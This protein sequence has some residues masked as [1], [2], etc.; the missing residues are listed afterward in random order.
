LA[1]DDS[2]KRDLLFSLLPISVERRGRLLK[3]EYKQLDNGHVMVVLT[4]ITEEQRL[5]RRIENE[6]QRLAMIVM[7]V[8]ESRDFFD[9][10]EAFRRFFQQDLMLTLAARAAPISVHQEIYRQ[11]HTL[12]GTLAQFC[13]DATPKLLHRLEESLS[14]LKREEEDVMTTGRIVEL[15]LSVDYHSALETDLAVLREALGEEF[16]EHGKGIFLTMSQAKQLRAVAERLMNGDS[17]DLDSDEVHA[18]FAQFCNLDKIAM[19]DALAAYDRVIDQV[20]KRLNKEVEPLAIDGNEDVWLDPDLYGPFLRS[21]VHVF[22]NAVVH[23]IEDPE[24]RLASGK[25][26]AGRID[27]VIR[28]VGSSFTLTVNDD[29]A[30]INTL[31]L[32]DKAVELALMSKEEA[33]V[34]SEDEALSLIF[35]DNLTVREQA[36]ELSGRGVGLAA[37]RAETIALGGH[38]TVVSSQGEGTRFTFSF[39]FPEKADDRRFVDAGNA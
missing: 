29:G 28:S 30:G 39:P 10:V 16:L 19:A 11:V 5:S 1:S 15:A 18:L 9:A 4:D 20:A 35:T 27:C 36:D 37:V 24:E 34:L 22:R 2:F 17:L 32:R 13:F 25:N 3:V 38:V 8:T 21:L 14:S 7:A 26:S 12:K 33:E 31:A 23:G 6:R